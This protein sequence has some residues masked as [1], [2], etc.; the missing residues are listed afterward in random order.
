MNKTGCEDKKIRYKS[1]MIDGTKYRTTL[2][3]KYENREP[4]VK[5][6]KTKIES[7]RKLCAKS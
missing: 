2:T 7:R 4:W 3:K 5:S 1:L 6:E